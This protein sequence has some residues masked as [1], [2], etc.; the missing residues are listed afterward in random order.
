[1]ESLDLALSIA[2][3]L[4]LA[5]A[6]G[7]R[8]FVPLLA[9]GLAIH[10]GWIEPAAGFD[11]L[12]EPA[13]LTALGLATALEVSAYYLPGVDNLLDLVAAPLALAAGV[14][15]AASVMADLPGWLRWLAALVAGGG[16]TAATYSL[17]S[18]TRA[19]STAATA[20]LANPVL[21]T[22]ELVGAGVL[23]AA[24]LLAPFVALAAVMWLVVA[25]IRRR[26]RRGVR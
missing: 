10:Y 21:S 18:L 5:A 13:A 17:T 16:A 23:A 22:G 19:K 15:V 2:T 1:M 26:R 8:A 7:F 14:V 4:A 12:G 6:A 11:W 25:A 20:G 9:T 3:G 24:A